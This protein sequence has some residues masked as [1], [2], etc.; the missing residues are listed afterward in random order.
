MS[1]VVLAHRV[2]TVL[3]LIYRAAVAAVA[4]LGPRPIT[5]M[6]TRRTPPREPAVPVAEAVTAKAVPPAM[7]APAAPAAPEPRPRPRRRVPRRR[8]RATRR[9]PAA[10]VAI[11]AS[12]RTA[13]AGMAAQVAAARPRR[14]LR[15]ASA[16]LMRPAPQ[17]V[18]RAALAA[19]GPS[20][21]P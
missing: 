21:A 10:R 3:P 11:R 12:Q 1:R 4:A 9:E 8:L 20:A 2:R 14:A 5:E 15:T 19:L 18:G 6:L 7:R 16:M 17:S 13:K